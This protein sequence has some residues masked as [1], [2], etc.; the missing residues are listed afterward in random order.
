MFL[1]SRISNLLGQLAYALHA[2][3]C[4]GSSRSIHIHLKLFAAVEIDGL[5][6]RKEGLLRRM[7]LVIGLKARLGSQVYSPKNLGYPAF[8]SLPL[9]QG[10]PGKTRRTFDKSILYRP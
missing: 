10:N 9:R 1:Q 4:I 2:A 7:T 6:E 5:K 8:L 3:I